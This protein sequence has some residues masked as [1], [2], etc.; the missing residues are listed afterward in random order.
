MLL[1]GS[2]GKGVEYLPAF[3]ELR[4][5]LVA[6]HEEVLA[7]EQER[8]QVQLFPDLVVLFQAQPFA[9]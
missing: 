1:I 6:A 8:N 4:Q 9:P 7:R 3:Q 2:S 5:L